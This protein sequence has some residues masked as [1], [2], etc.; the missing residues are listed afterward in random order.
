MKTIFTWFHCQNQCAQRQALA[1]RCRNDVRENP[2]HQNQH[3]LTKPINNNLIHSSN[4][5]NYYSAQ[6]ANAM[7]SKLQLFKY[8]NLT[9]HHTRSKETL[10]SP[11]AKN[12]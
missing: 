6:N 11:M 9:K 2:F 10:I 12:F 5:S 3:L 7:Y 8:P 1:V 4:K